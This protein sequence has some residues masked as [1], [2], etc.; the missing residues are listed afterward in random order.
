MYNISQMEKL[1]CFVWYSSKATWYLHVCCS[2]K[3]LGWRLHHT[4]NIWMSVCYVH[5]HIRQIVGYMY[6]GTLH[7]FFIN[8]LLKLNINCIYMMNLWILSLYVSI[9][10]WIDC[11]TVKLLT[12]SCVQYL[13]LYCLVCYHLVW[14]IDPLLVTDSPLT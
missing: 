6:P 1:L 10:A 8:I 14:R 3:I 13:I 11:P 7:S 12:C 4:F 5:A 9:D 2:L